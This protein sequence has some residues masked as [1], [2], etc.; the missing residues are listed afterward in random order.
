MRKTAPSTMPSPATTAGWASIPWRSSRQK[1]PVR[2]EPNNLDYRG[3]LAAAYVAAYET[4]TAAL[5]YEEI[6]KRDSSNLEAWYNLARLYQARKPL[7]SL[8]LYE[9]ITSAL[10]RNGKS[11][12]RLPSLPTNSGNLTKLPM[13]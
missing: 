9:Q 10:A 12:C 7:R 3:T 1:K 4:D 8:E 2:L 6:V 5:E 13:R 11:C